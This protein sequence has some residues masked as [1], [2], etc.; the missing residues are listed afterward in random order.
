MIRGMPSIPPL[1]APT[2]RPRS[3]RALAAAVLGLALAAST[4]SPSGPK[5]PNL[6]FI[7]LDT[8]R[9]DHLGCYGYGRDTSPNLDR[10]AEQSVLFENAQTAAPWTAPSLISLMTSLYPSVH[11][12]TTFNNPGQMNERV[13]TLAEVLERQ[14]YWTGAFTDGG[15]AKPQFG[16]G[17]G[18]RTYPLNEG[19]LPTEHASNLLEPSRLRPNIDRTLK[20]LDEVGDQPFFLFFHTYEIHGPY[21]PP[22][23]YVKRF[24]P[25]WNDAEEHARVSAAVARLDAG[26]PL[27]AAAVR[28]LL[29]HMEHCAPVRHADE[30]VQRLR[31]QRLHRHQVQFGVDSLEPERMQ[32]WR[33]LY[34]AEIRHSDFELKRLLDRLNSAKLR[35]N[36]VVVFVSDHGEGFGEHGIAG[37]GS[38]LHEENLRVLLMV[39]APGLEPRR[40]TEVVRTIDVMPTALELLRTPRAEAP[41]DLPMQGRSLV[42]VMR[43]NPLPSA[44]SF[45][46]ALSQIGRESRLWSVRD[47]DWRLVWDN[48][49]S[50]ARLY[51]LGSDPNETV[52][53]AAERP[54]VAERLL[55][56]M[57]AQC[58]LDKLF[59]DRASGPIKA[60]YEYDAAMLAELRKLGYVDND[61]AA[62][63]IVPRLL[64][65]PS[66]CGH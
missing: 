7:V 34:D 21:Q 65:R 25:E 32:F 35:E 55:G 16:L 53:I 11:G 15:F 29:R 60:V 45:S 48:D 4:C 14:G 6:V 24:R 44:P 50:E 49:R 12:V 54:E 46:H 58:E 59:F 27:D 37:H 40:V 23:E 63:A 41:L 18:F 66:Y 26:E 47:G 19:D 39:R 10:W 9:P 57:R 36:T 43:G 28:L 3:S 17:Q 20:W 38:V 51:D 13:T 56:L 42:P 33:D 64:E 2:R 61:S 1:R 22:E 30:A 52:N 62:D 8:L 5:P 31:N